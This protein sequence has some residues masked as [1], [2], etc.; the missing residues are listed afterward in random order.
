MAERLQRDA[1]VA[2][3]EVRE[4]RQQLEAASQQVRCAATRGI[5]CMGGV[6]QLA[7]LSACL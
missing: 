7:L 2:A 5:G 6:Q 4:L 1:G 3:A